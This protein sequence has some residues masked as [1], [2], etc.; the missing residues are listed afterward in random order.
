VRDTGPGVPSEF[1]P[2]LFEHFTR[3]EGN[4]GGQQGAGLG[5]AIVAGLAQA[6]HG[7]AWYEPNTPQGACFVVRIPLARASAPTPV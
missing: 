2:R 7:S 4:S 5:L 3:V 6:N 1:V